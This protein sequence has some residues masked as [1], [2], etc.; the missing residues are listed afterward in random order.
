MTTLLDRIDDTR[1]HLA[2]ES[3]ALVTRTKKGADGLRK[4][5]ADEARDWRGYATA[6]RDALAARVEEL[7][8]PHGIERAALRLADAG[9]VRAHETLH[10]RLA[11]L[12][13]QIKRAAPKKKRVASRSRAGSRRLVTVSN[14]ASGA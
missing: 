4:A 11:R 2:R 1:T 13:R 12:D 7:R 10:A 14:D 6:R 9:L 5:V 3:S 8:A